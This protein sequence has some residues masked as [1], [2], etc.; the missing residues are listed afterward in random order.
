MRLGSRHS[1]SS[2]VVLAP[3]VYSALYGLVLFDVLYFGSVIASAIDVASV[4]NATRHVISIAIIHVAVTRHGRQLQ[5]IIINL[6]IY[7]PMN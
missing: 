3:A 1:P 7:L 2:T 6:L 5:P 4:I